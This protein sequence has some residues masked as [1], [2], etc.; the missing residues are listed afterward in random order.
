VPVI[1]H[2]YDGLGHKIMGRFLSGFAQAG[3]W[4][5][6]DEFKRTQV[7]VLG[8]IAQQMLKVAQAIRLQK[9]DLR[10]PR[11]RDLAQPALQGVHHDEPGLCWPGSTSGQH[12]GPHRAGGHHGS[13][14][15]TD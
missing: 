12:Q 7:E 14:L 2:C 13:E 10:V 11:Q 1:V 6:V 5:C 3:T 4:A 9:G 15:R 8:V